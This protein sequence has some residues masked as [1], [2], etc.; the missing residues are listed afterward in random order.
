MKKLLLLLVFSL[1]LSLY[2]QKIKSVKGEYVYHAPENVSPVEAK[3][4]ALERAKIHAIANEFGELVS[5]INDIRVE[6]Q[7]G[8]SEVSF[9]STG[10]SEVKAEWIE[11]TGEPKYDIVYEGDQL[12]VT[13][14][15]KGKA[16]EIVSAGIDFKAHILRNGIE[17]KFESDRFK[18]SDDLYL[19]FLS[20]AKGFLAVYLVDDDNQAACLLPY[21]N[22]QTGMYPIE[23]NRRYVLFHKKSAPLEEQSNVDE[24][25]MTC[26]RSSEHNTIYIIFSPNQFTKAADSAVQE[27]LPRQLPFKD[28]QKWLSK[29]RRDDKDMQMKRIPVLVEK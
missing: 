19:S 6:N 10:G 15:V 2:A 17:D 13:C 18:D 11:T 28:F 27:N 4:T 29:C 21:R 3:R 22:Q 23:A 16:R 12:I 7:D 5:S 1:P 9:V 25:Y 24:Y 20:P 14:Y 8:H 26:S